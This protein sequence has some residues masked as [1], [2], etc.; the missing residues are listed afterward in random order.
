[1][2]LPSPSEIRAILED[3][4]VG[5]ITDDVVERVGEELQ[6]VI[7]DESLLG[8][9]TIEFHPGNGR[10]GFGYR[11]REVL[12]FLDVSP[13]AADLV[14]WLAFTRAEMPAA[15]PHCPPEIVGRWEQLEPTRASWLFSPDGSVTTDAPGYTGLRRWAVHRHEPPLRD[16]LWVF[17]AVSKAPTPL[18]LHAACP[19][20]LVFQRAESDEVHLLE[21]ADAVLRAR[22]NKELELYVARHPCACGTVVNPFELGRYRV[23]EAGESD[24]RV[25]FSGPC[26]ECTRPLFYSLTAPMPDPQLPR[27]VFG[28]D[29]EPSRLFAPDE[30][31][32]IAEEW[33]ADA[34]SDPT[35]LSPEEYFVR[36]R[37]IGQAAALID[38][39]RKTIP[40][41]ASEVPTSAFFG[42]RG[43]ADRDRDPGRYERS[44]LERR[45]GELRAL[46]EAYL[47]VSAVMRERAASAADATKKTEAAARLTS[48]DERSLKEHAAWL[49]RGKTGDGRLMLDGARVGPLGLGA[50][51]LEGARLVRVKFFGHK[52]DFA[53]FIEAERYG[54]DGA[55]TNFGH[56]IFDRARFEHC[57]FTRSHFVLT[58]FIDGR[59][60]GGSLAG[61]TASRGRWHRVRFLGTDLR[62]VRFCDTILD[63]AQFE[64]CDLREADLRSMNPELSA[65]GSTFNATFTRCDLRDAKIDLR[66]FHGTS[67]VECKLSG[68]SG[69]PRLD[70][71]IAYRVH[72][73]DLSADEVRAM[74]S[75]G[76]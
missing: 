61:S 34:P 55:G 72:A 12:A 52:A 49:A 53:K 38:D 56:A 66:R 1:M 17:D 42:P 46:T 40:A 37:K 8:R 15:K 36:L 47:G 76:P 3:N 41:G 23:S 18:A 9:V 6:R 64:D 54:C 19:G 7:A 62:K 32:A 28:T 43:T 63:G 24:R 16:D 22:S 58:D 59:V 25:T 60:V 44:T 39:V 65:L 14:A 31:M 30:L 68:M 69:K 13:R 75:P 27:F 20:Q 45:H 2:E 51:N 35:T 33:T 21:R 11:W 29:A 26:P 4:F 48:L 67:F 74:W 57:T 5:P 71:P 50:A 10:R 73:C 70:G